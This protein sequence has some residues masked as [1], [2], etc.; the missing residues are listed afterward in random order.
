MNDVLE[1]VAARMPEAPAS[2]PPAGACDTHTHVFGP[3][4]RHPVPA[5]SSY[6]PP[7]AP[8]PVHQEMLDRAGLS[9]AVLIQP[10]PYGTDN[11]ALLEA[12]SQRPETTRGVGVLSAD[13]DDAD[14]ERLAAANIKGLRF[15]EMRDPRGGGRYKGSIGLDQYLL[16]APRMKEH[17]FV[18]H[19][20]AKCATLVDLL[21]PAIREAGQP[22]VI[23]HLAGIDIEKGVDDP[24]F[25]TLV[26]LLKDGLIW[27]KLSLCRNSTDAPN[28]DSQR[29]FHE[30]L[31]EANPERLLWA[32]DWPF[33][34]MYDKSPDVGHL[35][36]VF[37]AWTPEAAL[38]RRILVDN[39]ASL[40][41]FGAQA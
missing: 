20:W 40:Y 30:A 17:G 16:L 36:D 27:I 39:P 32:S 19:V 9:R 2:P 24:D 33:V 28:Y 31:I 11:S 7:I 5:P 41:G 34:R 26:D 22:F 29:P 18:P 6:A 4:E 21:P 37:A 25:R 12:L 23:D 14:F 13:A 8:P 3:F 10:A 38:R 15:S 35:L 1:P